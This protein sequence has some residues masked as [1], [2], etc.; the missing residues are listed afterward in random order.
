MKTSKPIILI[1]VDCFKKNIINE[2]I[3]FL[4]KIRIQFNIVLKLKK[5]TIL[6]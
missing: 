1:I 3:E 4:S 6:T 2:F 5:H